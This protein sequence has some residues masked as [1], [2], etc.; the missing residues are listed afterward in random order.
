M[1]LIAHF[2][3]HWFKLFHREN[4]DKIFYFSKEGI[5]SPA[6]KINEDYYHGIF[7]L[8]DQKSWYLREQL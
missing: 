4:Y 2:F 3:F 5:H 7:K 6:E 1:Q 8:K